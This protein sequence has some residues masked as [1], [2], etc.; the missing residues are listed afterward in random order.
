MAKISGGITLEAQDDWI[1]LLTEKGMCVQVT[2][3]PN[4]PATKKPKVWILGK[5]VALFHRPGLTYRLYRADGDAGQYTLL[6]G[7]PKILA[8]GLY[9][10]T[11]QQNGCRESEGAVFYVPEQPMPIRYRLLRLALKLGSFGWYWCCEMDRIWKGILR[12]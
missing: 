10:L 9:R 7:I 5:R 12:K 3:I 6:D 4:M 11:A 8:P 2:Q 1:M